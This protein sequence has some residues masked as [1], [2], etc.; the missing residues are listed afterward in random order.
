[1]GT[2]GIYAI[3]C[4]KTWRSYVG[5]SF[6]IEK[7]LKQHFH[8]LGKKKHQNSE[9]QK[10][11]NLY[12][13]DSFKTEI[14]EIVKDHNILGDREVYWFNFSENL[15]NEKFGYNKIS[16]SKQQIQHFWKNIDIREVNECWNWKLKLSKNGYGHTTYNCISL[17]S[18][19]I[20]FYLTNPTEDI[21]KVIC[22]KCDNRACCNPNHLFASSLYNNAYDTLSKGRF[23]KLDW[24][25]VKLI[26]EKF[27]QNT[28]INTQELGKWLKETMDIE[29]SANY[30]YRVIQ[31]KNWYDKEYLVPNINF[32]AKQA[33][34]NSRKQSQLT[35]NI[36]N[37]LRIEF[38]KNPKIKA[39]DLAKWLID[40]YNLI[41]NPT[42][43]IKISMNKSWIDKN[44][45]PPIRDKRK[46]GVSFLL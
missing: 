24:N 29:M 4:N 7:R 22:H 15:Y 2:C 44:Y 34:I 36:V 21:N 5:Q 27:L 9:F 1:M 26:R 41:V 46:D 11:F 39:K 45:Y 31:N 32:K 14:L 25:I 33:S 17:K 3:V 13:Q 35:E 12:G 30:L 38:C 23:G 28:S 42:N 18:H 10:D 43:L 40:K 19:R 37:D 20:A 6:N 16:L 8:L